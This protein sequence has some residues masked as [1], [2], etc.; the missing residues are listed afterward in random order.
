MEEVFIDTDV[1][2]SYAK[3]VYPMEVDWHLIDHRIQKITKKEIGLEFIDTR[4]K[5]ESQDFQ[6]R[7]KIID[8]RKY[9]FA[10][11]KYEI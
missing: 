9:A 7:F 5:P 11:I 2:W 1:F 4:F 3:V 10:K 8:R 6:F